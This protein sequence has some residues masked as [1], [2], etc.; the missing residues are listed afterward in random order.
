MARNLP[1]WLEFIN[2]AS[3]L[4]LQV[5]M[6]LESSMTE[7]KHTDQFTLDGKLVVFIDTLRVDN[8]TKSDVDIW[9]W[10]QLSWPPH[11]CQGHSAT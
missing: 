4:S 7:V 8:T 3:P 10:L 5:G 11:K 1:S 6:G 9:S 2:L